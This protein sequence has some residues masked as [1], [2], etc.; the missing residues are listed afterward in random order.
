MIP[1]KREEENI[2]IKINDVIIPKFQ[3]I[4]DDI[5]DHNHVHYVF[6]G[7][8]G[9]TKSSFVSEAIPLLIVNISLAFDS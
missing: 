1:A 4:L 2:T 7:G 5:L 6:K 9:S 8:R 3:P